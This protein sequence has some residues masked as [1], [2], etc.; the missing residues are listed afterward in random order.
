MKKL[1]LIVLLLVFCAINFTT[2]TWGG[3]DMTKWQIYGSDD[4]G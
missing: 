3:V 1:V 4:K 2:L